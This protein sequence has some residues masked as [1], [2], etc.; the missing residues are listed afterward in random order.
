[1]TPDPVLFSGFHFAWRC[2][3]LR[4]SVT[5]IPTPLSSF[6]FEGAYGSDILWIRDSDS[7]FWFSFRLK[8]LWLRFWLRRHWQPPFFEHGLWLWSMVS[9]RCSCKCAIL[10]CWPY[11][12]LKLAMQSS[13][14][15]QSLIGFWRFWL[16]WLRHTKTV[17]H[18][19]RRAKLTAQ[20]KRQAVQ[21]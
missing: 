13:S 8:V 20:F 18:A 17:K 2:L 3:W 5:P 12:A 15:Q 11:T 14:Y 9:P 4:Y 1:M 10:F 19:C 7:V 6:S 16:Y 21:I